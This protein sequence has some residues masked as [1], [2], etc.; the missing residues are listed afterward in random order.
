MTTELETSAVNY[1]SSLIGL[2]MKITLSDSRIVLGTFNC[3]D[4]DCNI[5]LFDGSE[6]IDVDLF[7]EPRP[8]GT[9]TVRKKDLVKIEVETL[10]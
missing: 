1:L 4:H 9:I 10:S 8:I 3:V 5:V 7:P 6:I 2:K